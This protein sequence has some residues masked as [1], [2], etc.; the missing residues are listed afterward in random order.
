MSSGSQEA[1]TKVAKEEKS[2]PQTPAENKQAPNYLRISLI[3]VAVALFILTGTLNGLAGGLNRNAGHANIFLTS[4]GK[5]DDTYP[6]YIKPSGGLWSIW[7]ADVYVW[8]GVPLAFLILIIFLNDPNGNGWYQSSPLAAP[9]VTGALSVN[10]LLCLGWIFLWDRGQMV[11]ASVFLWLLATFGVIALG[12]MAWQTYE[13]KCKLDKEKSGMI[14]S[15]KIIYGAL[16]NGLGLYVTRS[17]IAALQGTAIS[18]VY[19]HFV[20]DRIACLTAL[21]LLLIIH[22][23]WFILAHTVFKKY[24][25]YLMTPSIMVIVWSAMLFNSMATGGSDDMVVFYLILAILIIA[26]ITLAVKFFSLLLPF[27]RFV[28][29]ADDECKSKQMA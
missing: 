29:P 13:G 6:V 25:V 24:V 8:I 3:F 28:R 27:V 18:L 23:Y 19:T 5:L 15:Y 7:T 10:F 4:Q 20:T 12:G 9:L 2:Q 14:L 26:C 1:G 21:S 22:V 11:A 16:M 17:V